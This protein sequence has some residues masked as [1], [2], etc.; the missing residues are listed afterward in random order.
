MKR[1]SARKRM[2]ERA[3]TGRFSFD[4]RLRRV[5]DDSRAESVASTET[6]SSSFVDAFARFDIKIKKG[7]SGVTAL[8]IVGKV[9][10]T[11]TEKMGQRIKSS[12]TNG[13]LDED[14]LAEAL[15]DDFGKP[16]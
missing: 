14:K 7:L 13:K 16:V 3:P 8:Q 6:V 4:V 11:V 15:A 9:V 5:K 1:K 2:P 10:H 12:F